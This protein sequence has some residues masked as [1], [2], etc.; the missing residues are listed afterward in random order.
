[1]T[2]TAEPIAVP[3]ATGA[4]GVVRV[5]GTRISLDILVNAF[6]AGQSPEEIADQYPVLDLADV[7]AVLAYYLRNTAEV[8]EY[9]ANLI[10]ANDEM[11]VKVQA[12]FPSNGLRAR[13]LARRES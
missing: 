12:Q 10:R 2:I 4:D 3:L 6:R 11:R 1:M 13:V 5:G 9:V 7:Y 8:D